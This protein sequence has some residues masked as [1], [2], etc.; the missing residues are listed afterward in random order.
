[1]LRLIQMENFELV[2]MLCGDKYEDL[3]RMYNLFDRVTSGLMKICEVMTS[4]IR[5]SLKQI[6]I[7]T[8]R[9][10]DPVEFVQSLLDEKDKYDKIRNYMLQKGLKGVSEDDAEITLVKVMM[11]FRYLQD[12]DVF[13]KYYIK[14][15]AKRLLSGKTVSDDAEN[16]LIVKG[17][18]V[19]RNEPM[20]KDVSED[21]EFFVNDK[22]SSKLYKEE[23]RKSQIDAA[24]LR[25]MK[26][27]KQLDHNNLIAEVAKQLQSRF[28]A[29]P[30]EL[31]RHRLSLLLR[32]TF[33]REIIVTEN[34]IDILLKIGTL[35]LFQ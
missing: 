21:D 9:L 31:K 18:D 10:K 28:L 34:C 17:R 15:L 8:E 20:S 11:L 3:G 22:F 19:L 13:A 23:D 26:S 30:T 4:Q 16:C 24:I 35:F 12:K 29:N 32:G 25:I 6:V 5:E 14:H 2:N 27:R 33:W 7:D 1:M